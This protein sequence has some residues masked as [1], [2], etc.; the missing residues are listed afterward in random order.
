MKKVKTIIPKISLIK[1]IG[2]PPN[3]PIN[4]TLANVDSGANIHLENEATPTMSS[5][6]ISNT[7]T[8]TLT[9]RRTMD[10]SH[11]ATLHIPG[12]T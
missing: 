8:A 11:V 2:T 6:I 4:Y 9:D 12:L 10:L 5:V 3:S 7:I 1:N